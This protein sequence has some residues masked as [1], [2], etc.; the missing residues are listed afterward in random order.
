VRFHPG[1]STPE[2]LRGSSCDDLTL[3]ITRGTPARHRVGST[4]LSR[5]LGRDC[6]R[7]GQ[8]YLPDKEFR[9]LCYPFSLLR[10]NGDQAFL[11]VSACRHAVR[12]I[13]YPSRIG[14]RRTV[15]ED[16]RS[17]FESF[18]LIICT[19]RI[20]T[21]TIFPRSAGF[22]DVPAYGRILLRQRIHLRTVI[23]TAAVYWGFPSKLCLA[24]NSS[25]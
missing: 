7:H 22:T 8:C 17:C 3:G 6:S 10:S 12:T 14:F 24:A 1:I 25:G 11:L 5:L 13:S 2:S 15:S 20:V 21:R 4:D 18:L 19:R 16:S 23:V 9:S